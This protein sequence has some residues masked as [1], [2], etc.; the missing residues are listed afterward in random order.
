MSTK[1]ERSNNAHRRLAN[2]HTSILRAEKHSSKKYFNSDV[3][4]NYHASVIK[5][6]NFLGEVIDKKTKKGIFKREYMDRVK[7]CNDANSLM[8]SPYYVPKKYRKD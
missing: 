1:L 7:F 8:D 2:K 6:Q 5:F 3:K 4:L